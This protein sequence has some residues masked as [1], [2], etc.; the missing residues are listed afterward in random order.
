M[1]SRS[2]RLPISKS[3]KS[4]AGVTLTAPVPNSRSTYSSAMIGISRSTS[5]S[6]TVLPIRSRV[7]LVLGVDG[8]RGVAEHGFGAG[9]GDDQE[10]RLVP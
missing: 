7:A 6:I 8:H 1:N 5:G 3:L 9:G 10:A 2:W 4:W